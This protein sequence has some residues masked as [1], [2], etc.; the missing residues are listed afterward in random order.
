MLEFLCLTSLNA[1]VRLRLEAVQ[2]ESVRKIK[3]SFSLGQSWS[4]PQIS[5]KLLIAFVKAAS[6]AP[7]IDNRCTAGRAKI[8]FDMKWSL[9]WSRDT[10]W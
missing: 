2:V 3:S 8:M 4:A 9:D 10:K 5:S 1:F 7:G 6:S